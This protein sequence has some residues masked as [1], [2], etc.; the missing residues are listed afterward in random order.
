MVKKGFS[1]AEALIV[2]AIVSI[3]FAFGAKVITTKPKP[4][5]AS[6]PHGYFECY[7]DGG[8]MKQRY[9]RE[10]IPD[11]D[12]PPVVDVCEFEP[13]FGAAYFNI[14][15]YGS[16]YY[17]SS[18]PNI[19]NKLFINVGAESIQISSNGGL[20][21]INSTDT[22]TGLENQKQSIKLFFEIMYPDS[23][24]YNNGAMRSGI[25]ISW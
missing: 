16:A 4:I 23:E 12:N 15:A 6:Y 8:V 9:V 3:L 19:T 2:M 14:N 11:S 7:L 1:L 17:T 20:M 24:M 22:G 25:M 21:T 5:K 13:P 10:N 18:E